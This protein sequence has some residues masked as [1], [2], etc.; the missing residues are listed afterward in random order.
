M[1]RSS[2]LQVYELNREKIK[3]GEGG[4]ANVRK[5]LLNSPPSFDSVLG[6]G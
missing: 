5:Y 1:Y 3:W 4:N 6:G 2:L